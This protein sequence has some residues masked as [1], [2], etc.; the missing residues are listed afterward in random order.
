[1]TGLVKNNLKSVLKEVAMAY[2][3]VVFQQLTKATEN[4]ARV[5]QDGGDLSDTIH[6]Y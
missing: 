6:K 5:Y 3:I 4:T 1:M 2:F